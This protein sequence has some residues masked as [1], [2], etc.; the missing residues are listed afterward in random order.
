MYRPSPLRGR[1]SVLEGKKVLIIDNNQPTR[2]VRVSVLR[3]HG[4][5]V[6][7]AA[8]FSSARSLQ[9]LHHYDWIFLDVRRHFPGEA[10]QFYEQI[11]GASPGQRFAFLD[12]AFSRQKSF[13]VQSDH[14]CRSSMRSRIFSPEKLSASLVCAPYR[15]RASGLGKVGR[16][17]L[18]C[19][20]GEARL[21][22]FSERRS[23]REESFR[24][25][26]SCC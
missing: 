4:I 6:E 21:K 14:Y 2:D 5:E 18:Y 20:V 9:R 23:K 8:N 24:V 7:P 26:R 15:R 25:G 1:H 10:L 17:L 3:S 19:A 22:G 11:K 13:Y 16:G 12:C